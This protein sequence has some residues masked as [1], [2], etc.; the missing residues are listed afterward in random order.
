MVKPVCPETSVLVARAV[1]PSLRVTVPVGVL[2]PGATG[3]TVTVS[4]T[5]CPKTAGFAAELSATVV[6]AWLTV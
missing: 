5:G 3:A 6:F 2:P 4:T 1:T